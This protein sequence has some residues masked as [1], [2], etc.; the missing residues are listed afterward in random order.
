VTYTITR[1]FEF[2]AAHR[3]LGHEGK[4][5]NLHGHHYVSE[6]T[7]EHSVKL[8]KLGMV[9]DF[10]VV[11][12][13]VGSW[14]DEN[15]DHGYLLHPNDPIVNEAVNQKV[16]SSEHYLKRLYGRF[17]YLMPKDMNPTAEN[18]AAVLFTVSQQLL[19]C[20][21]GVKI[22]KVTVFETPKCSATYTP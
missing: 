16:E 6:V 22:T 2:D 8:N 5:K 20:V 13:A 10:A 12:E 7:F 17:P 14:I 21:K 19:R 3:V 9:V 15:W 11:K 4:C 1:R 18:I